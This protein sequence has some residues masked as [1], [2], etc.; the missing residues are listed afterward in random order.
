MNCLE[1]V[2][3]YCKKTVEKKKQQKTGLPYIM[4]L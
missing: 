1:K 3:M 4:K 2:K